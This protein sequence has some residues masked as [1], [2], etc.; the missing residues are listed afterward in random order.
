M[1]LGDAV[2]RAVTE[3][4]R[5]RE[6]GIEQARAFSWEETARRTLA[7]YEELL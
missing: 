4:Q 1:E 6:A 5:L 2:R 3:R 7:V